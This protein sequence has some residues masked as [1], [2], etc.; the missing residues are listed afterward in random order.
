L[1]SQSVTLL[2]NKSNLIPYVDLENK[3]I[4]SVAFGGKSNNYFQKK[5]TS[6]TNVKLFHM[7]KEPTDEQVSKLMHDLEGFSEVIVSFHKPSRSPSRHF[8]VSKKAQN[9]LSK[10]SNIKSVTLVSFTNPYV[11]N[12][13]KE[14]EKCNAVVLAYNDKVTTQEVAAQILFGGIA[15][16]GRVPV[17]AGEFESGKGMNTTAIRFSY[18]SPEEVGMNSNTLA[19]V[20]SIA[21]R[22]I[23]NGATPGCQILIVKNQKVIWNKA[24][25]YQT[26]SKKK[27][28][29]STDI[30]DLASLTKVVA[31]LPALM[32]L[33]DEKKLELDGTLGMYL[34]ELVAGTPYAKITL[35]EMLAHQS[36]LKSWIPFYINT[37][38]NGVPRYDIYSLESSSTYPTRVA[39]N[40]YI[41]K[42]YPDSMMKIIVSK[43]LNE[44][45]NYK[46]SDLGYYFLKRIVEKMTGLGLNEY[47]K[48]N[49]YAPLGMTTS[50]YLPRDN[51]ELDQIVPTENDTYFRNQLVH[52]DVHDPGAAMQGGVGGHAGVFSNAEDLAKIW[53]MYLNKGT[54]GGKR[55]LDSTTV[56]EFTKCQ[57]C[58]PNN[59]GNRRA[60]GFDKP[61]RGEEGG[62]TCNCV[63]YASFG[64]TGFTGTI[65]WVDPEED[66]I[67]IFLSNRIYP[68]AENKKLITTNVRTDIMEVIY[69][70]INK[71]VNP[72]F[73]AI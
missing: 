37:M 27:A 9:V 35:R 68:T 47:A 13:I 20:D 21:D 23:K 61:V 59:E 7:P 52:G 19:S 45:G 22:A 2:K 42:S 12:W 65:S 4:A 43:N 51:F 69:S 31:T 67:Y 55:Y 72:E 25:G 53:Q 18:A 14:T 73:E 54:Y 1:I 70:S 62:P 10:I 63:S 64:H 58:L 57:Y 29:S 16:K 38:E 41:N 39:E 3:K 15:A 32:K 49:F 56:T 60:I 48:Q 8:G 50:G 40:L 24:Y 46:Y 6:Y 71:S 5:L 28:V 17:S 34:P 11:F 36:G 30:Y 26:Y 66:L 33:V 44:P